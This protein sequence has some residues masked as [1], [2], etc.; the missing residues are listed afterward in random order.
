MSML[1]IMNDCALKAIDLTGRL[2]LL[3]SPLVLR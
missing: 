1:Q 3:K 2:V